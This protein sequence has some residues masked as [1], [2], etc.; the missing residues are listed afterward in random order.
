MAAVHLHNALFTPLPSPSFHY[1]GEGRGNVKPSIDTTSGVTPSDLSLHKRFDHTS[2]FGPFVGRSITLEDDK[3]PPPYLQPNQDWFSD[4]LSTVRSMRMLL[5][6]RQGF[7][8]TLL[9]W[10]TY[11]TIRYFIAVKVYGEDPVRSRYALGMAI[12]STFTIVF[13]AVQVITTLLS[14]NDLRGH[15]RLKL[16]VH[17]LTYISFAFIVGLTIL[18]LALV[19]LWRTPQNPTQF[20]RS[21]QGR[22]NWDLDIVWSGTGMTCTQG[23]A[24]PYGKWLGAA[25]FRLVIS[26]VLLVAYHFALTPSSAIFKRLQ[27]TLDPTVVTDMSEFVA[28]RRSVPYRDS[29]LYMEN[30]PSESTSV[31]ASSNRELVVSERGFHSRSLSFT[32][33]GEVLSRVDSRRLSDEVDTHI[34]S[35]S[36]S[37]SSSHLKYSSE[38]AQTLND[39]A[40]SLH[41]SNQSLPR[42]S[43]SDGSIPVDDPASLSR[44][45]TPPSPPRPKCRMGTY[46]TVELPPSP[47][48]S[49]YMHHITTPSNNVQSY[50]FPHQSVVLNGMLQTD[51]GGMALQPPPNLQHEELPIVQVLG[52]YIHRMSTIESV[53]SRNPSRTSLSPPRSPTGTQ[54]PALNNWDLH[55]RDSSE[56]S[57]GPYLPE[58]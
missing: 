36:S 14:I 26:L 7:G 13:F 50:T 34:P 39:N 28:R 53:R 54:D 5:W 56:P 41:D 35:S 15:G 49:R 55:Q 57:L 32:A 48:P 23:H 42:T 19:H 58:G 11:C 29:M 20:G 22:C 38:D 47:P 16:I 46:T 18:N 25:I 3:P 45:Y 2:S 17:S 1:N 21:L 30:S 8:V 6:A 10:V 9:I 52:S 27:T 37:S 44:S 4:K 51:E 12:A 43:S 40:Q 24:A 31:P 33:A